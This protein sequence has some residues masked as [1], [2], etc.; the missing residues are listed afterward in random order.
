[1]PE[2][3]HRHPRRFST[4]V[5]P[6]RKKPR[7]ARRPHKGST[8]PLRELEKARACASCEVDLYFEAMITSSATRGLAAWRSPARERRDRLRTSVPALTRRAKSEIHV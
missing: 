2:T 5:C 7:A 3:V 6:G 1:M 4:Q 8:Q